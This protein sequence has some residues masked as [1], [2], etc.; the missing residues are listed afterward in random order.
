MLW[1]AQARSGARCQGPRIAGA[2]WSCGVKRRAACTRDRDR[3]RH[4]FREDHGAAGGSRGVG[5]LAD[6]AS[7]LVSADDATTWG[8]RSCGGRFQASGQPIGTC[9]ALIR[10]A[11]RHMDG[12][13]RPESKPPSLKHSSAA[14][15]AVLCASA[16]ARSSERCAW[17][18]GRCWLPSYPRR[19]HRPDRRHWTCLCGATGVRVLRAQLWASACVEMRWPHSAAAA[20]LLHC[21]TLLF[22]L[23]S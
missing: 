20:R 3:H 5:S 18:A 14:A 12:T 9:C 23:H 2:R 10:S 11:H 8:I 22:V 4:L 21:I 16:G 17:R 6:G 19:H 13:N 1:G 15:C 7:G